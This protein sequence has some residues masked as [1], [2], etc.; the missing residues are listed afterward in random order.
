MSRVT[1]LQLEFKDSR[2]QITGISEPKDDFSNNVGGI[3]GQTPLLPTN[4]E[5]QT[6]TP[7]TPGN[8]PLQQQT[9]QTTPP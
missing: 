8:Q 3:P 4:G 9:S 6:P 5:G 1:D 7:M 2:F